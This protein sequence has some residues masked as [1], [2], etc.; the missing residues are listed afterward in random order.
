VTLLGWLTSGEGPD[1]EFQRIFR[2]DQDR[3]AVRGWGG[4]RPSAR[5]GRRPAARPG[6]R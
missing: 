2:D 3:A 4:R 6:T 1:E 5:P